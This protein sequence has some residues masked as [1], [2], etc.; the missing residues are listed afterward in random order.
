MIVPTPMRRC[1]P[2]LLSLGLS[3][4]AGCAS[5]SVPQQFP[6]RS[7]SA[8]TAQSAAPAVVTSSLDADPPLPGEPGAE[9]YQLTP[10]ASVPSP[11]AHGAHHHGH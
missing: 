2:G 11:H 8:V 7:A 1:L 9:A 4:G 10:G 5:R 6:A 3:L